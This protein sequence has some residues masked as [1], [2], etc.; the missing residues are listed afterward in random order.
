MS[1]VGFKQTHKTTGIKY[2]LLFSSYW[3][4][5]SERERAGEN[6]HTEGNMA[7]CWAAKTCFV[8]MVSVQCGKSFKSSSGHSVMKF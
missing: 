4:C 7:S 2:V 8:L 1:H 3:L 5:V 6:V